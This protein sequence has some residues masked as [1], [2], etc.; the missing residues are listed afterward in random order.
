[1]TTAT[2]SYTRDEVRALVPTQH[3]ATVNRWLARGDGIAIYSNHDLGSRDIGHQQF[4]SFGS[5]AAQLETDPPPSRLPDIGAAIN[6][7]YYLEGTYR[8]EQL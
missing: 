4:V 1:M 7:R 3:H 6:W 2:K 5:A 8:G